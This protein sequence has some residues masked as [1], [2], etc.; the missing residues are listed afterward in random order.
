MTSFWFKNKGQDY[1]Q[2]LLHNYVVSSAVN[3]HQIM[4]NTVYE[5]IKWN[6]WGMNIAHMK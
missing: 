2:V 6:L 1:A 5:G 4:F 3:L